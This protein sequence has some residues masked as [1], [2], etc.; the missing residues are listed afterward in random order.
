M[1]IVVGF[2]NLK[3]GVGKT[4]V[5]ILAGLGLV[6]AGYKVLLKDFDPQG[7]L[8]EIMLS[9]PVLLELE[10]KL[11]RRGID[12]G[13]KLTWLLLSD[14]EMNYF[15][16]SGIFQEV[17]VPVDTPFGEIDVFPVLPKNYA[18]T[19]SFSC[20]QEETRLYEFFADL[21]Y[22][23]VLVDLPPQP[24]PPTAEVL[25]VVDVVIPPVLYNHESSI[26]PVTLLV[27]QALL[28]KSVVQSRIFYGKTIPAVPG[29]VL[30]MV[31]RRQA[32]D[33]FIK[34]LPFTK[35][36]SHEMYKAYNALKRAKSDERLSQYIDLS[37]IGL[38]KTPY[39]DDVPFYKSYKVKSMSLSDFI[40]F[41]EENKLQRAAIRRLVEKLRR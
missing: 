34:P 9:W 22:D 40:V 23:F 38:L 28:E 12:T 20:R 35:T 21:D 19:F 3:G 14:V 29:T 18:D 31:T 13:F 4:H 39:M 32:P 25:K 24:I 7:S 16:S 17:I 15:I 36:L 26:R 6:E 27:T 30:N 5:T 8:S 1:P 2:L 33:G 10:K 41:Y 11:R 37:K